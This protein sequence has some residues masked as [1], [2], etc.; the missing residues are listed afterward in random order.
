LERVVRRVA[1][2]GD[3]THLAPGTSDAFAVQVE[4]RHRLGEGRVEA[5][6]RAQPK[7]PEQVDDGRRPNDR[8]IAEGKTAHGANELL[9]LARR[10]GELRFVV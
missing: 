2:R 1:V 3:V 5:R 10:T 9:E 7:I 8:R 6:R 4:T